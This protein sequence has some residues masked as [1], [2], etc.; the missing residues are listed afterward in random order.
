MLVSLGML[1]AAV[2]ETVMAV[3]LN[4]IVANGAGNGMAARIPGSTAITTIMTTRLRVGS[5]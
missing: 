5:G 3:G 1:S 4:R 2:G